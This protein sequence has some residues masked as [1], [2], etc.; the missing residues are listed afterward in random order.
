VVTLQDIVKT[1][2]YRKRCFDQIEPTFN[3]NMELATEVD[4][5]RKKLEAAEKEKAELETFQNN[6]II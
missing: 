3:E 2:K 4:R 6:T 5:L 1:T